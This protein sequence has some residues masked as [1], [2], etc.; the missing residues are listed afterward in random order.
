MAQRALEEHAIAALTGTSPST[1]SL[2]PSHALP[3]IPSIPTGLAGTLLERRPDVAAAERRVAAAN[4]QIGVARAAYFPDISL[5]LAGGFESDKISPW[6]AA[7]EQM[8]SLGPTLTQ[9]PRPPP[10]DAEMVTG[11]KVGEPL[12]TEKPVEIPPAS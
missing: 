8:W 7:P 9:T 1:F 10:T 12:L 11:P 5:G 4:A 6:F 2:A 3:Y